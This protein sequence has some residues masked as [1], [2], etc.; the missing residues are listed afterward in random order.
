MRLIE[1]PYMSGG[2]QHGGS[3]GP[4]HYMEAG[5]PALLSA[6]GVAVTVDRVGLLA[7][8]QP[9]PGI[10]AASLAVGGQVARTVEQAMASGQ[11]PLV[12][13]GSC[14]VSMGV[15]SGFDHAQCGIVWIEAHG[16]F[17]T[18]GS[19]VSGF[20]P[21]MSLAVAT[22]HCYRDL[23][24]RIGNALPVP[25]RRSSCWGYATCLRKR[26]ASA[27]NAQ[28]STWWAGTKEGPKGTSWR[29]SMSWR[30]RC[31]RSIC[32]STVRAAA[33]T[34][35]DPDHDRDDRTLRAGL[36]IV[37]VLGECV[38]EAEKLDLPPR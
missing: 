18:P 2:E 28:P 37:Q 33:L 4:Q 34:N 8:S 38:A 29:L 26:S 36:R 1:V 27:W 21:G 6:S 9:P 31:T 23:W 22:G 19:S 11:F 7:R 5:A 17:N 32:T 20:F 3:R 12:L 15:L 14:D 16:D 25:S 24:A 10:P 13:A 30:I 35:Y